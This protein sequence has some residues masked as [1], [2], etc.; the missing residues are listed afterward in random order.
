[1]TTNKKQYKKT[2][3]TISNIDCPNRLLTLADNIE[4][5]VAKDNNLI[6]EYDGFK[7]HFEDRDQVNKFNYAYYYS[8]K[9]IEREKI[10]ENYGYPFLR[11]NKFNLGKDP[12]ET[13]NNK[14]ESFFLI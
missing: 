14:L 12:I 1:M 5:C 8:D 9:D 6:I 13:I 4:N 3:K 2:K 7:E 10:L 11:F